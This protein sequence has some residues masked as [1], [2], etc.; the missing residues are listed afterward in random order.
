M[1]TPRSLHVLGRPVTSEN[2]DICGE[3]VCVGEDN[4]RPCFQQK[5]ATTALL[6]HQ[7]GHRW[8]I[9]RHGF[10]KP[11]VCVAFA[12]DRHGQGIFSPQLQWQVWHSASKNFEPAAEMAAVDAPSQLVMICSS[13]QT[14]LTGEY[15][16]AGLEHGKAYFEKA[17]GTD[18]FLRF[19]APEARWCLSKKEHFGQNICVGFASA[20]AMT[21]L[22]PSHPCHEGLPW[23]FFAQQNNGFQHDPNARAVAAPYEV[24]ILGRQPEAENGNINGSYFMAGVHD[25]RPLYVKS[26]TQS[27][28]RYSAKSDRWL[29]DS[30]AFK[31][32]PGIMGRFLHWLSTGVSFENNDKC[33]AFC[34]AGASTHPG[35]L[36]LEWHVIERGNFSFD[37]AVRCTSAPRAVRLEGRLEDM[38]NGDICG[39]YDLVGLHMGWPAYRKPDSQLAVRYV[40]ARK[41]WVVDRYGFRDSTSCVAYAKASPQSQHPAEGGSMHWEVFVGGRGTFHADPSIRVVVPTAASFAKREATT[42]FGDD[43]VQEPTA[44]RQRLEAGRAHLLGA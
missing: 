17:D 1:S 21:A 16:I 2:S 32:K 26:G 10:S 36:E 3:Y 29:V 40:P 11:E 35:Q 18:C 31:D 43:K 42:S 4:G 13:Q 44:K 9:S 30:D 38:E 15:K 22:E 23:H 20:E 33:N 5:G 24:Q 25:G 37:P 12:T 34:Q 39:I 14:L 28:I 7:A 27:V 6:Y 8:V 19:F 41:M